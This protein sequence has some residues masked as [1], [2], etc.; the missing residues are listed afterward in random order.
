[1]D[2]RSSVIGHTFNDILREPGFASSSRYQLPLDDYMLLTIDRA[3]HLYKHGLVSNDMWRGGMDEDKFPQFIRAMGWIGAYDF[4]LLSA[5]VDH[6]IAGNAL[7]TH[8]R[9]DQID[10][11][12]EEINTFGK[13][14]CFAATE[15]GCGS[16]LHRIGTEVHYD[17]SDRSLHFKTPTA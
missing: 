15:I 7:L 10:A 17:H 1:M 2:S 11:Y 8:G 5:I 14:Y 4:A 9:A 16:D 13:V 12:R 3:R 6:Q